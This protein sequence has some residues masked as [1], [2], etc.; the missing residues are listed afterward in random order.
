MHKPGARRY[1]PN[2]FHGFDGGADE[3]SF[4]FKAASGYER[5]HRAFV[6]GSPREI[7]NFIDGN[8]KARTVHFVGEPAR[9]SGPESR[10][11]GDKLRSEKVQM[12]RPAEVA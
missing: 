10:Q 7:R 4:Q 5:I 2:R 11:A 3:L 8:K 12:V 6:S 9:E 1:V